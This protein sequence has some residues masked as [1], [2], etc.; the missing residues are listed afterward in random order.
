MH[1]CREGCASSCLDDG[2]E[3]R[4]L[5]ALVARN[6]T[7]L[8]DNAESQ[9]KLQQLFNF[10]PNDAIGTGDFDVLFQEKFAASSRR[11]LPDRS[12]VPTT[13]EI[14]PNRQKNKRLQRACCPFAL[15]T[16]VVASAGLSTL[17]LWT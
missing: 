8:S 6:Y 5:V 4:F 2:L 16:V 9:Q 10:H 15:V 12:D 7:Q 13:S 14:N 3:I 1:P 17:C 11:A